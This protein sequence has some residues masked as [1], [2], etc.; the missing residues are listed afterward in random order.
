M[1]QPSS[2]QILDAL[3]ARANPE[4]APL[5]QRFFK[6]GPGQYGE[7]DVFLGL[8]VPLVR[9][10][11]K[12]YRSTPLTE[13][14]ALVASE[15]HESRLCAIVIL[16][17]RY[18][19]NTDQRPELFQHYLKWVFAGRVNNWDLVDVSAPTF[20]EFLVSTGIDNQLIDRLC[21]SQNL[22]ERRVAVLLSAAFIQVNDFELTL[23]L[24]E[25]LLG[26]RHDLMHKA[27]GWML[28]EV[29]KRDLEELR[30]FLAAHAAVMPRTMLRYSIEKLTP[31]ERSHWMSQRALALSAQN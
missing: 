2:R 30:K 14:D 25:K 26:D 22:W 21:A 27:V 5:Y 4:K 12:Q 3:R 1:N 31:E 17:N 6:T 18:R 9:E 11:A 29:G 19:A 16:T 28:R 20:G 15:F 24:A 23:S 10:V 8:T 7:G 13:L